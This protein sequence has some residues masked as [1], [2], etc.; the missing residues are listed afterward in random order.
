MYFKG[1]NIICIKKSYCLLNSTEPFLYTHKSLNVSKKFRNSLPISWDIFFFFF[2]ISVTCLYQA[3]NETCPPTHYVRKYILFCY[4][5][6]LSV[7]LILFSIEGYLFNIHG[8]RW[9]LF[10]SFFQ[11]RNE[12]AFL[13]LDF[14]MDWLLWILFSLLLY[15]PPFPIVLNL[16]LGQ[17]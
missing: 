15:F 7:L 9:I 11:W 16:G 13:S 8:Q 2:I 5:D 14:I 17:V 3:F 12:K 6:E 4:V 1:I 10:L